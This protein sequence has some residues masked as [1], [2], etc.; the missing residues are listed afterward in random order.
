MLGKIV[1]LARSEVAKENV[2]V[3]A[4]IWYYFTLPDSLEKPV[5]R[6][7]GNARTMIQQLCSILVCY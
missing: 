7:E 2:R 5:G 3:I 1:L 4:A 6:V